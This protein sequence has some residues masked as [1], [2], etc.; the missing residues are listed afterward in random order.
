MTAH[1]HT[2]KLSDWVIT[3]NKST[4]PGIKHKLYLYHVESVHEPVC[5]CRMCDSNRYVSVLSSSD[6]SPNHEETLG[7]QTNTI[8]WPAKV[9]TCSSMV[10]L[11]RVVSSLISQSLVTLI[12][13]RCTHRCTHKIK[14]HEYTNTHTVYSPHLKVCGYLRCHL[15]VI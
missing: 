6:V 2:H 10:M 5:A 11:K 14:S 12:T 4:F 1:P 7:I 13:H 8:H 15:T 9:Q 3:N